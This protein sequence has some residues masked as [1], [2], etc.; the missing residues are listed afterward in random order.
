VGMV[1]DANFNNI[2][3]RGVEFYWWKKP[4]YP[5]KIIAKEC[6]HSINL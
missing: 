5:K 4:E 1:L 3:G 2:S 6:K